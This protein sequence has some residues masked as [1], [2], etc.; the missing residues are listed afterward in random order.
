MHSSRAVCALAVICLALFGAGPLQAAPADQEP[1]FLTGPSQG[2]PRDIALSYLRQHGKAFGLA[3]AD[4][5]ELVVTSQYVSSH[6]GMTHIYLR[7]AIDGVHVLGT[8]V[9]VNVAR[10]GSIVSVG[11]RFSAA[12]AA[13]RSR[14]ARI[15]AERAL[16]AAARHVGLKLSQPPAVSSRQGGAAS[17]LTLAA[18]G[19]SNEPVSARLVYKLVGANSVRLGW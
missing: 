18:P 12:A 13:S 14:A 15:D 8:E 1:T 19:A 7:Q 10:D 4:L 2:S 5:P 6:T 16:Q 11:G 17:A 9:N 3:A